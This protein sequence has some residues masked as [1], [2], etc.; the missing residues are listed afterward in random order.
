MQ[1]KRMIALE[2]FTFPF[3]CRKGH[4]THKT[5]VH[6]HY[7]NELE[8]Y[9]ILNGKGKFLVG[10]NIHELRKGTFLVIY[11]NEEHKVVQVDGKGPLESI[12]FLVSPSILDKYGK[13][14]SHKYKYPLK[15]STNLSNILEFKPDMFAEVD[16]LMH[17][18]LRNYVQRKIFWKDSIVIQL[19]KL[20][21]L[22]QRKSVYNADIGENK[23]A[24]SH[25]N[26]YKTI[27]YINKNFSKEINLEDLADK[28]G[29]TP[30]YLSLRFKQTMGEKIRDYIMEKRINEARKMLDRRH[31]DKIIS[32]AYDV[33]FRDLSHFNHVFRKIT[34]FTPSGYRAIVN[35]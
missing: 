15:R 29:L 16:F 6:L 34:G 4:V 22:L 35:H 20:F 5:R 2:G 12:Y 26:I 13:L 31:S 30:Y 9:Y 10:K 7:H 17:S 1:K 23:S 3:F 28:V 21:I 33:G 24:G 14:K 27:D 32:I 18:I 25:E 8:I 11:R 19:I